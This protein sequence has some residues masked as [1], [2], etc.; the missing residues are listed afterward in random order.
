M[1]TLLTHSLH[2]S[3]ERVSQYQ[4]SVMSIT[5]NFPLNLNDVFVIFMLSAEVVVEKTK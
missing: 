5:L 3:V 1:T 2:N 4:F